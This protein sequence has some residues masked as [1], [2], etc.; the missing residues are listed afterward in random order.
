MDVFLDFPPLPHALE[1]IGNLDD[2]EF[3]RLET[4]IDDAVGFQVSF[5]RCKAIARSVG[6]KI[7]VNDVQN[8]L[9]SL[10]FLR[11]RTDD[12]IDNE[13]PQAVYEVFEYV[14]LDKFFDRRKHAKVYERIGRL[15]RPTPA[16]ETYYQREWLKSGIVDTAVDVD[17]FVDLRARFSDD[18]SAIEEL[19]PVVIFRLVLANDRG[20][21]RSQVFQLTDE[22]LT[23][24]EAGVRSIDEQLT[25]L[26][27]KA[28]LSS[29]SSYADQW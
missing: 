28:L 22:M 20:E 24:F 9:R 1:L 25:I 10:Q 18:R 7:S 2:D 13:E 3:Q 19:I 15:L 12:G 23:T 17:W 4:A 29:N 16:A 14:G 5:A 11:N 6:S 26:R 8:I 21:E 27:R